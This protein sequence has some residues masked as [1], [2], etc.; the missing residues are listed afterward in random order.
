MKWSQIKI[1]C[2]INI[3]MQ[4]LGREG[5]SGVHLIGEAVAQRCGVL[6]DDST[7]DLIFLQMRSTRGRL[8]LYFKAVDNEY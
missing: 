6:A 7:A 8:S 5:R 3:S 2:D 1:Y 4:I